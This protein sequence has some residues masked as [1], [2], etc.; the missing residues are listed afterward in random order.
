MIPL[1]RRK[2]DPESLALSDNLTDAHVG[3]IERIQ[4][5]KHNVRVVRERRVRSCL[6]NARYTGIAVAFDFVRCN[7]NVAPVEPGV[8]FNGDRGNI[9][10]LP[11]P[12]LA[13]APRVKCYRKIVIEVL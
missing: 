2:S 9:R 10:V 4:P 3:N 13:K 5:L 6:K 8:N 11:L 12:A 1:K 7:E